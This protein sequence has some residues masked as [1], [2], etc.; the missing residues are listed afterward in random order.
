M[1]VKERFEAAKERYASVGVD[2]EKAME[3]L[4]KIRL[5]MHCWQGDDV[6]GFDQEGPLSG[7]IQ[8]TGNY[9]YKATTPEELMQD[10]DEVFSLVPGQH[11]LNLHAC[12]AVFGENEW[13]DR[14]KLE[15]KHFQAW[16]DFAKKHGIGLDF[17]PT[18]FSHPMAEQATL[19]SEDET[20]R[21]FWIN[22]CIACLKISEYFATE[23]GVPCMMNIWIPDGFKDVIPDRISPRQR[24]KDSL[25]QIL[26]TDYDRSK[27]FVAVESKVFGIGMESVTVGSQEFY[28][29]YAAKNN[30]MCLIDSGHFHPTENVADKLSAMLLFN[31]KMALHVT[32]PVRW[33][34]DHVV[35]Y[36]DDAK[37]IAQEIV[38]NGPDRFFIGM[39]YFDA[40][41]N[42]VSAW[43]NGMRNF[44]KALLNA[45]LQ[46]NEKLCRLQ[47]ERNFTE[48][49]SLQ[50]Q[51]KMMPIG[52][53]WDY[54]CEKQGVP[55]EDTW[56]AA[57]KKYEDDVLSKR[58]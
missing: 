42:R 6:V 15:P 1:T 48:L 54:Y 45:E 57:C 50:E 23:T 9:P 40:S 19:S 51:M 41:I 58:A 25:D 38:K 36:N 4:S 5:S 22:H 7:G 11:K 35:I 34:S 52:D 14:D 55:T 28:L 16:V 17:N 49:M 10:I 21:K 20:V 27:V 53:V 37:E 33:D 46:P 26:A 31:D 32:R 24:L 2:V 56:F 13:V 44:L 39:D 18:M 8:T 43:T 29:S 30:I 47:N 12:Y 3:E